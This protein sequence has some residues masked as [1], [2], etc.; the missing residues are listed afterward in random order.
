[1]KKIPSLDIVEES[2]EEE[3]NKT[4]KDTALE[5]AL[6]EL[7]SDKKMEMKTD[8]SENLILAMSRGTIFADR[9]DSETMRSLILTLQRLFVSK[10][11]KG[12]GEYVDLVRNA[13]EPLETGTP[14]FFKGL[15]GG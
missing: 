10:D 6:K 11:R 4:I 9:Y 13:Q 3:N 8:L 15:F 1:M 7:F 5:L 12:R 14:S 2:L